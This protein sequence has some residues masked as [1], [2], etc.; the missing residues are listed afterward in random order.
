MSEE[1]TETTTSTTE[2]ASG[3]KAKNAELL[4][5]LKEAEKRAKTAEELA[6]TA[7]DEAAS[8]AG[9]ELTKLQRKYEKLEK[10]F[11]NLTAERDT[12]SSD[13]RTIRVDNAIQAA[14]GKGNVVPEM[15]DALA[16]LYKSQT[17]YEDGEATLHGKAIDE[18]ISAHLN[19]KAGAMFRR[20]ADNTGAGAAGSEG[21]KAA[22]FTR[23]DILGA[24]SKE[25]AQLAATNPT[26]ANAILDQVGLSQLKV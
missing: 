19:S 24:K 12:L 21:T 13:L 26:E 1:T 15:M 5:K 3:L 23:E 11:N 4:R 25:F 18:A 17:V 14:L 20:A 22:T 6:E 8:A 7:A 2:D 9:D 16:A 10:D